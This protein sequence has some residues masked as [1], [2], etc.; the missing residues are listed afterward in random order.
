MAAGREETL[1]GGRDVGSGLDQD[2]PWD[3]DHPFIGTTAGAS[4]KMARRGGGDVLTNDGEIARV[5]LEDTRTMM[6]PRTEERI[7]MRT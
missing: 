3:T 6:A 7:S 4:G 2:S 5:E 1:D